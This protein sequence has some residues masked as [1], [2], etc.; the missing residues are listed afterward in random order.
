MPKRHIESVM[1]I[2]AAAILTA[3]QNVLPDYEQALS[4][5]IGKT[6]VFAGMGKPGII[7]MKAASTF[8]SLGIPATFLHPGDA[9]HGD[10][11][12]LDE[13]S[14]VVILSNSGNTA[15]LFDLILFCQTHNIPILAIT[16][17]LDSPLARAS[18]AALC[19]GK[20]EEACPMGLAPT[21]TTA[22]SLA[23]CDALAVDAA[24]EAGVDAATFRK[25]HPGGKLGSR[26]RKVRDIMR[27]PGMVAPY[28]GIRDIALAMCGDLP[29]VCLVIGKHGPVGIITDGDL[30]RSSELECTARDIMTSEFI[31][32][33]DT[34]YAEEAVELMNEARITKLMVTDAMGSIIGGVNLHDCQ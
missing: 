15:E 32:I 17:V 27:M 12:L 28:A 31:T 21:A 33:P 22:A 1:K 2:E 20:L 10:L 5:L 18:S 14:V 30:R 7:G 29:G 13:R 26:L 34:A 19:Y 16:A 11:G 8:R 6:P 24:Q 3:C 4:L 9:S 25:H 23:L